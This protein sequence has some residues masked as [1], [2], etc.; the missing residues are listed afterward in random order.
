MFCCNMINLS[1]MI[2]GSASRRGSHVTSTIMEEL[3]LVGGNMF[4]NYFEKI[5]KIN[6]HLLFIDKR[7]SFLN[8]TFQMLLYRRQLRGGFVRGK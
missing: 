7:K 3:I 8:L 5:I 1:K 4:E 2:H 6:I